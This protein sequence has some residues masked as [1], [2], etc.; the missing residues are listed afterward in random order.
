M[1]NFSYLF[2]AGLMTLGLW[3]CSDDADITAGGENEISADKVYMSFKLE[4]PTAGRSATDGTGTNSDANPDFE[5]GQNYEN[6]VANLHVVLASYD[7]VTKKY[8][9]LTES[10]N[11]LKGGSNDMYTV[12]FESTDLEAQVGKTV[13]VFVFCNHP[14]SGND[15]Y[16]KNIFEGETS[17]TEGVTTNIAKENAFWMSNA[18]ITYVELPEKTELE[19]H[20]TPA[21]A[22]SLGTVAVERTAARF[23]FDA[24]EAESG[25][26]ANQ[27]VLEEVGGTPTVV[28]EL[29]HMSLVN[30]SN[31]FYYLRHVGNADGVGSVICNAETPTNY[32]VDSDYEDKRDKDFLPGNFMNY[33]YVGTSSEAAEDV[34]TNENFI[35]FEDLWSRLEANATSISSLST[36]ADDSWKNSDGYKIWCYAT[37]N[38]LPN[39]SR[40]I[41]SLSTAVLFRGQLKTLNSGD[42][43]LDGDK[44]YV[45]NDVLYG[46][47]DQITT[48]CAG[49]D[50]N[51]EDANLIALKLAYDALGGVEPSLSGAADKGFTVY[52]KDVT[53]NKYYIYY[54]YINRHNDNGNPDNLGIM[55]YAVVRN[56]VYKLA[57][58]GISKYGHPGDPAG[59]PDPETPTEPD[60]TEEIYFT[61]SVKVLPWVVRVNNI[62]F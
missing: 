56:N 16:Y 51:T 22:F 58:T 18:E 33:W 41:K 38:T 40:Q 23:D 30:M 57:V 4:L 44:A 45:F 46:T 32:V 19:K 27:Y 37:E 43:R 25:L 24:K 61:V 48:L 49:V 42:T 7:D 26:D 31:N 55:E 54:Y 2:M 17:I 39:V 12:T 47:W 20:N 21:N 59:D 50:H 36:A 52:E 10:R 11:G 28:V 14:S 9:Y 5:V 62:E 3:S 29:Q 15:D 60:E 13:Y 8:A 34:P 1:K 35:H 6:N 53:D